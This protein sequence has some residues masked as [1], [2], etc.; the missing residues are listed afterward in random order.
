VNGPFSAKNVS[1]W[2]DRIGSV[3]DGLLDAVE[4]Q[5]RMNFLDDVAHPMPNLV[6]CELLGVP[7]EDLPQL[8]EWFPVLLEHINPDASPE[9]AA[10]KHEAM[11][12][13]AEYLRDL[14]AVSRER[15]GADDLMA[16]MIAAEADNER[17]DGRELIGILAELLHAGAESTA[18]TMTN[19]LHCLLH[20]PDQ[21]KLLVDRPELA[22]SAFEEVLRFATPILHALPRVALEPVELPSGTIPAGDMVIAVISSASRDPR[23]LEDPEVF[24][25]TRKPNPHMAF[26]SGEHFCLG[27]LL[28]RKESVLVYERLARGPLATMRIES[29][30]A[31]KPHHIVRGLESLHVTW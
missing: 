18:N 16:A 11:V 14:V 19:G 5:R 27:N 12:S 31:W 20:H 21:Q 9:F 22:A 10:R 8:L 28:A 15:E 1:K 13:L 24:D 7:H 17:L 23:V 25:I 29:E 6:L 26:G 2:A 4:G 30:P 3:T